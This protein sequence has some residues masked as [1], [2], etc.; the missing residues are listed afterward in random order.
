MAKI[1]IAEKS[2]VRDTRLGSTIYEIAGRTGM[3]ASDVKRCVSRHRGNKSPNSLFNRPMNINIDGCIR[4]IST[5]ADAEH[6]INM[7]N[8]PAHLRLNDRTGRSL[9]SLE[10]SNLDVLDVTSN[11]MGL[12]NQIMKVEGNTD[13]FNLYG[14]EYDLGEVFNEAYKL[15]VEYGYKDFHNTSLLECL[16]H[17]QSN[18]FSFIFA[19]LKGT[20]DFYKD[21]ISYMVNSRSVK[22]GGIIS[23]TVS[24][25]NNVK[26]LELWKNLSTAGTDKNK[27]EL[28]IIADL[29]VKYGE[30]YSIDTQTYAG[31]ISIIMK[32]LN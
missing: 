13:R 27:T 32:R 26:L 31:V 20:Y 30:S 5:K 10:G 7:Y 29:T 18:F 8:T 23:V 19:D 17:Y 24:H 3:K 9:M 16:E 14:V 4:P 6:N 25:R 1:S 12:R 2:I 11:T 28:A 22:V 21:N 15:S